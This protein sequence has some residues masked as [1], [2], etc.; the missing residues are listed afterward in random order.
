VHLDHARVRVLAQHVL[1]VPQVLRR[2]Q[3]PG[4]AGLLPLQ[5]LQPAAV[6]A[7]HLAHVLADDPLLV[8]GHAELHVEDHRHEV[9][10]EQ[11][12]A[13]L[14][15]L[16]AHRMHVAELGQQPVDPG[17]LRIHLRDARVAAIAR[18][19][20]RREGVRHLPA[21][22]HAELR[23]ER[24]QLVHAGGAGTRHAEDEHG[25][26]DAPRADLRV[27]PE[28]IDPAQAVAEQPQDVLARDH[29]P[30]RREPR[31]AL[32]RIAQTCQRLAKVRRAEVVQAR[33]ARRGVHQALRAERQQS[34]TG[35][36]QRGEGGV[37]QAYGQRQ[38][39]AGH[40]W[41]SWR[42]VSVQAAPG[43]A[44]SQS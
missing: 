18:G 15:Q 2:L 42:Q 19:L 35:A 9:V 32:Q 34:W 23:I 40:A 8:R 24:Q 28:D 16:C 10:R 11:R 31:V 29:A 13:L 22:R 26:D 41:G 20:R 21:E 30:E 39:G 5:Q 38:R 3:H 4:V 17:Q 12:H 6:V 7:E 14:R 25:R 37:Q 43:S 36:P 27:A 1:D 33:G 44:S